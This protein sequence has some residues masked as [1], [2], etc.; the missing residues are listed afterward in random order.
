MIEI[1]SETRRIKLDFQPLDPVE[2][3][4]GALSTSSSEIGFDFSDGPCII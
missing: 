3:N 2:V 4:G 1:E